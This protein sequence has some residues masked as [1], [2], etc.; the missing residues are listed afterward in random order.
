MLGENPGM[1]DPRGVEVPDEDVLDDV[2]DGAGEWVMSGMGSLEYTVASMSL[3][4]MCMGTIS[5]FMNE[6]S[7]RSCSSLDAT[8]PCS[9]CTSSRHSA[10]DREA[11][12]STAAGP[13][14]GVVVVLPPPPLELASP[15]GASWG[16]RAGE[17]AMCAMDDML[18]A[19]QWL[20]SSRRRALSAAS[21]MGDRGGAAGVGAGECRTMAWAGW[22][23]GVTAD[24]VSV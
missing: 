24:M 21:S 3:M 13:P 11:G 8:S 7:M 22:D 2:D 23:G 4:S 9:R 10:S 12:D 20:M 16:C 14:R 15:P 1:G 18:R 19:T 6:R 5:D 17:F